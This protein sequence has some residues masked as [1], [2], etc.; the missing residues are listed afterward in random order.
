MGVAEAIES[1]GIV[2]LLGYSLPKTGNGFFKLAERQQGGPQVA[3]RR[4]KCWPNTKSRPDVLDGQI[5]SAHLK[6]DHSE[7]MQGVGMAGLRLQDLPVKLLRLAQV[8]RLMLF[9]GQAQRLCRIHVSMIKKGI[10]LSRMNVTSS[11]SV[12]GRHENI[13]LLPDQVCQYYFLFPVL[14][15]P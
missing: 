7:Q 15:H 5:V 9:H 2:R 3:M 13:M 6:C 14:E 12:S 10:L 11:H 1:L 4:R 8:T